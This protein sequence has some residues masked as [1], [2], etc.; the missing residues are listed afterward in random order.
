MDSDSPPRLVP[1]WSP[2]HS[3]FVPSTYSY[4]ESDIVGCDVGGGGGMKSE[5]KPR[6]ARGYVVGVAGRDVRTGDELDVGQAYIQYM[7]SRIVS[8]YVSNTMCAA[9]AV[10]S[11]S[12]SPSQDRTLMQTVL[13]VIRLVQFPAS[14][15]GDAGSRPRPNEQAVLTQHR[16]QSL[17]LS[18]H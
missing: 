15:G 3:C 18:H 9:V 4:S 16:D 13:D 1:L 11:V 12:P 10:P 5:R 2:P 7:T 14:L 17:H 6:G 8:G